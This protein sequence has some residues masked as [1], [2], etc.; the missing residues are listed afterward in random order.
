MKYS[1][2]IRILLLIPGLSAMAMS[3]QTDW[4]ATHHFSIGI[5][6]SERMYL[7]S[8]TLIS[9][10][11][12]FS[13]YYSCTTGVGLGWKL[14]N[15]FHLRGGYR[16]NRTEIEDH[17]IREH[18]PYMEYF[19]RFQAGGFRISN[20]GRVE[21]RDAPGIRKD[22][23][24]RHQ[25]VLESPWR[26]TAIQLQP[27]LDEEVFYS[28]DQERV[29]M[30]WLAAGVSWRAGPHLKLRLAY[31]WAA[32]RAGASWHHRNILVTGMTWNY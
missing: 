28:I 27:Y 12:D 25:L 32:Q 23:R 14:T 20:R 13:D 1:W 31:R 29:M 22:D 15:A 4:G 26:L 2:L 24:Y 6:L 5:D 7:L 16:Q 21:F 18:R 10:R 9:S 3:G 19:H 30:N 11:D 8:R 17:W